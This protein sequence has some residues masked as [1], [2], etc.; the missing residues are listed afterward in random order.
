[1]TQPT[2]GNN[3]EVSFTQLGK[4]AQA[5]VDTGATTSSI[6]ATDIV[7]QRSQNSVTFTSE[8]LSQGRVTLDLAGVQEVHSADAGGVVRP[9]V[10]LDVSVDGVDLHGVKFNLNDRSNMD[11]HVLIGQNILQAGRFLVDTTKDVTDQKTNN[12]VDRDAQVSEALSMLAD[13][14]VTLQEIITY[15]QTVAV[16]KLK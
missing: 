13:N 1:M 14:N 6:H 16:S 12:G 8:V 4:V 15:L 2:I 10:E 3:V 5:K 11:C 9:V 7:V